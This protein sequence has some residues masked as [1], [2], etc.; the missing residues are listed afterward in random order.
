[1]KEIKI[2]NIDLIDKIINF[3]CFY[4][5]I[6][7]TIKELSKKSDNYDDSG[8]IIKDFKIYSNNN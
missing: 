2:E 3:I 5:N 7:I 6:N 8:F 1:M 4:L